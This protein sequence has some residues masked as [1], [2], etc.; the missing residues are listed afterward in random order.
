MTSKKKFCY[1]FPRPA[2]TADIV[3]FREGES[4]DEV[5]LIRRKKNPYG[6]YWA[7]PGGFVDKGEALDAAAKRELQEETGLTRI[8]LHQFAAFGDPGR[9]P[10]GH[11]VSIAFWG[12][13]PA[14]AKA[15]GGDDADAAEWFSLTQ[16]PRLAFDHRKIIA[17]AVR[18]R[19]TMEAS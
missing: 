19:E 15:K 4:G 10:R 11:T 3:L 7:I 13:A 14:S 5:L 17:S 12:K 1:E 18:H 8:R 6:G 9:D 16:L 2:V